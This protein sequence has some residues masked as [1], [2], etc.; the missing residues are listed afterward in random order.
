MVPIIA[1]AF[2][3]AIIL[4]LSPDYFVKLISSEYTH[5]SRVLFV[6]S[7][8][9]IF[10]AANTQLTAILNS[11]GKFRIITL[12]AIFNLILS[13]MFNYIFIHHYGVIGAALTVVIVEGINTLLQTISVSHVMKNFVGND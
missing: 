7:W 3:G 5:S 13:V 4:A 11:L 1:V 6:L 2:T 9:L 12:I 8:S 10:K